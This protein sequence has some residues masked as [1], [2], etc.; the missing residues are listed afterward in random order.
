MRE[1]ETIKKIQDKLNRAIQV[2][3]DYDFWKRCLETL[4][5]SDIALSAGGASI[6]FTMGSPQH[7]AIMPTLK[8]YYSQQLEDQA[9]KLRGMLKGTE[10][11]VDKLLV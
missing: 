10:E 8:L 5:H 6:R 1:F 11:E 4:Q 7:E 9:Q 2:K 3:S